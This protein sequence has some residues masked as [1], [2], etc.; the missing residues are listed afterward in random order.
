MINF[1][2]KLLTEHHKKILNV[3][4][5]P[6][7]YCSTNDFFPK[8][9]IKPVSSSFRFP[10]EIG[11]TSDVLFQKTKRALNDYSLFPW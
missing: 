3:K 6:Y 10:E 5:H 9:I 1:D 2:T 11:I 8:N 7:S 4:K